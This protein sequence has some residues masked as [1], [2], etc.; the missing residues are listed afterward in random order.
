M[1]KI[2]KLIP[3][4]IFAVIWLALLVS[5]FM[6]RDQI[7][8]RGYTI[9]IVAP[10]YG[11][12]RSE[13]IEQ[14]HTDMRLTYAFPQ[15]AVITALGHT[16]YTTIIGTNHEFANVMRYLRMHGDFFIDE[17]LKYAHHVA[18]L[19][20]TAAID[21]F[22]KI[23]ASDNIFYFENVLFQVA[24]VIDDRDN[25]ANIY[26]P[27]TSIPSYGGIDAVAFDAGI[28]YFYNQPEIF[29]LLQAMNITKEN[30]HIT[31]L[32]AAHQVIENYHYLIVALFILVIFE[33]ITSKA[34]KIGLRNWRK[35]ARRNETEIDVRK[36]I[37]SKSSLALLVSAVVVAAVFITIGL[38]STGVFLSIG[39]IINIQSP[40]LAIPETVFI[41]HI[42]ELAR[43]YFWITVVFWISL[44]TFILYFVINIW[45]SFAV[46]EVGQQ[47]IDFLEE[48]H[49]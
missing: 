28:L 36:I 49:D 8:G 29:H 37:F 11:T 21:I 13:V 5:S 14:H 34:I 6:I 9:L 7:G 39:E 44:T 18:V 19:N 12:M 17:A 47:A 40:F 23:S 35:I 43:W 22:G 15:S 38:E 31:N 16:H 3:K 41:R 4:L 46:R 2:K 26:V 25:A 20:M 24:G 27:I 45:N 48:S 30:Y 42:Q 1:S 10:R 33:A 32:F